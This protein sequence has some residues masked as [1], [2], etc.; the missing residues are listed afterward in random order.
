VELAVLWVQRQQSHRLQVAQREHLAVALAATEPQAEVQALVVA[1]VAQTVQERVAQ[2]A[3]A[4]ALVLVAAAELLE[5][6]LSVTLALAEMVLK[7]MRSSSLTNY[8][9]NRSHR[10]NYDHKRL[11]CC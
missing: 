1:A 2:V 11:D 4:E 8:E 7:G 3:M 10:R 6:T 9:T 5:L